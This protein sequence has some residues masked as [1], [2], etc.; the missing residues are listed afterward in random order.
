[1]RTGRAAGGEVLRAGLVARGALAPPLLLPCRRVLDRVGPLRR[2]RDAVDDL[3]GR[4]REHVADQ[5]RVLEL[6]RRRS[7]IEGRG[8]RHPGVVALAL[9]RRQLLDGGRVGARGG[10]VELVEGALDQPACAGH[11]AFVSAPGRLRSSL[12]G[13]RTPRPTR[14]C[15]CSP[16]PCSSRSPR[17]RCSRRRRSPCRSTRSTR[18]ATCPTCSSTRSTPIPS[19]RRRPTSL[20][21]R[22]RPTPAYGQPAPLHEPA[23][24]VATTDGIAPLPFA[25]GIAGALIV[26]LAAG[27]G[28]HVMRTRRHGTLAT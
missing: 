3:P 9:G 23:P 15:R 28:L 16:A 27:T 1:M 8:M 22:R 18:A 2:L 11:R 21:R 20:A 10:L 4:A 17:S 7:R 13:S 12:A 24:V 6:R 14:R 19:R 25:L 26:G 5:L